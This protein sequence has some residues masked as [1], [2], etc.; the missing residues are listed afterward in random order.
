M[1]HRSRARKA[2]KTEKKTNRARA[3]F[4][5]LTG[6]DATQV[7]APITVAVQ[8]PG[9]LDRGALPHFWHPNRDGIVT[10]DPAFAAKL[11]A[12]HPDLRLTRPPIK[13]PVAVNAWLLWVKKE[14]ITHHLCPGW[15]LLMAWAIGTHPLPL[16]ERIFAAIA[17]FDRRHLG[18]NAVQYFDR[19]I[20]ERDHDRDEKNV[21]HRAAVVYEAKDFMQST[22]IKNI[23]RG[24]KFALHHDGTIYPSRGE[25]NWMKERERGMLPKAVRDDLERRRG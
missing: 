10:P 6:R 11:A 13:A 14:S 17:H 18:E 1:A 24:N 25:R 5:K 20:R 22:K 15:Q 23:G 7:G 2:P 16:D 8:R 21:K 4:R 19:I 9:P 3:A 12:V